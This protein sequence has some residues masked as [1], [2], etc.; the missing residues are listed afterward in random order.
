MKKILLSVF[1]L[2]SF[3]SSAQTNVSTTPE[4][5]NVVLEEYTG[6]TCPYCPD[7]HAIA[8]SI[9]NNN[10]GDVMLIN[11]H[12]GGYAAPQGPGTDFRTNYGAALA[13]NASVSGYPTGS[14]NRVGPSMSRS[15]WASSTAAQL[16]QPSPVNIWSEAIIDM[17]T[18]TLTVNVEIYYTGSQTVSSN[19][20][21][22]A[23][24]QNNIEGPQ[25]G[26][27][28][29]NPSAILP[30][31]NYNHTHMLR[32]LLTGQW[33]DDISNVTQG[34][35]ETRSYTW[36][37]PSNINGVDFDPTNIEIVSFISEGQQNILTGNY[38]NTS[39]IFPNSY[40]AY[41]S[42]ATCSDAVCGTDV[43]PEV[44][45]KNYGNIVLTSL[46]IEY[47][48]NGGATNTY[49]WIGSLNSGATQTLSLP[50]VSFSP[51]ANNSVNITLNNPNGNIDQNTSNNSGNASF[52]HFASAG[53]VTSGISAGQVSVAI[54]TDMY[55]SETTW[56][57]I[58]ENGTILGSGGPYN[59]LSAPGTSSQP[60][61]YANINQNECYSF[62]IEDSYGDGMNGQYGSGGYTVTD[63]DGNIIAQGGADLASMADFTFS[64]QE[65]FET[66]STSVSVNELNNTIEI[67]PNPVKNKLHINGEFNIIKIYDIY[68]KLV[69]QGSDNTINTE[70]LSN[71]I[72][73][74]NIDLNN[75][76]ITKRVTITK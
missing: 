30:N 5:K 76:I 75:N 58:S 62:I 36:N 70:N 32:H 47:S 54:T 24:L 13:T 35:F 37:M 60:T 28:Q 49:N 9:K 16:S 61:E 64:E 23:V 42:E 22:V 74:T 69:Y 56:K 65:N 73:I 53:Q 57:I 72:Y 55:G 27:A 68:G 71:G 15:D 12:T 6:I 34:N 38:A 43:S 25:S 18:N 11:I 2:G 46:D 21:N 66:E 63:S 7:G 31:G 59:N 67:Y 26:G 20:L 52:T 29:Y 41:Y 17:G 45:F 33:G 14:I 40:D 39:I 4:N 3:L 10:P 8:N 1:V 19:K 44:T 51:Q 48:I 50:S